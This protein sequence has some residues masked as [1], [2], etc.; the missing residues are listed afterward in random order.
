MITITVTAHNAKPAAHPLSANFDES[1][2]TIGRAPENTLVLLDPDRKISRT[3]ATIEH[4]DGAY[5]LRD[6][7]SVVPVIVNGQ[8]LGNGFEAS[9]KD[10]DEIRIGPYELRVAAQAGGAQRPA[11]AATAATA[12]AVPSPEPAGGST[13]SMNETLLSWATDAGSAADDGITSIVIQAQQR[14]GAPA[15]PQ[16]PSASVAASETPA[17]PAAGPTPPGPGGGA[18]VPVANAELLRAL[19]T[20]AGVRDVVIPGGLTPELMTQIGQLMREATS[21]MLDLLA[22]RASA[23]R[24]VRAD[25]TVI[26]ASDNNPLKFA[27]NIDAALT[28]LLVPRGR[29]FMPPLRAVADAYEDLRGHQVG[30]MAG[31]RSALA[32]VVSRFNPG[33]LEKRLTEHSMVDSFL[34]TNRKAKLW[35]HFAALYGEI[36][37][38]AESDFNAL[39]GEEFLKAYR[40]HAAKPGNQGDPPPGR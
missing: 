26:V 20:G 12:A 3:H 27:P 8:A 25:L 22:A 31:M 29:G 21:G 7:S 14:A 35:D 2:G 11:A 19:L 40:E 5:V 9:L 38:E 30:F 16:E 37:K 6:Q 34:P 15:P 32:I 24:Q 1:G 36:S 17:S 28:H 33:E 23:K 4:R 39:F 10:G 18:D 13:P